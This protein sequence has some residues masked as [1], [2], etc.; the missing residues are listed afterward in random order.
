MVIIDTS[1]VYKWFAESE[2]LSLQAQEILKRHISSQEKIIV[3]ALLLYEIS[4]AWATKTSLPVAKAFTSLKA[5]EEFDLEI[6]TQDWIQIKEALKLSRKYNVSVY[7]AVYV[8]LANEKGCNL[9]TADEKFIEKVK[10]PFVKT[11]RGI[12]PSVA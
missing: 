7:D 2:P 12:N 11:L 5:L 3:P 6:I 9:I 1:V 8:V 4:N 10:L